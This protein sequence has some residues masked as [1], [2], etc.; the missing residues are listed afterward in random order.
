MRAR[1]S[2]LARHAKASGAV[3][4]LTASD[5]HVEDVSGF[6]PVPSATEIAAW[7]ESALDAASGTEVSIR[8]VGD[9]ESAALNERFRGRTGPTNV[10]AFAGPDSVGESESQLLGDVVIC[11]PVVARE[12]VEQRVA[13]EAHWA[14]I[15]IHG[16]LH[17]L[18]YEHDSDT[19]ARAME[20]R[21]AALLARFGFDDPYR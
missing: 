19:G 11:A 8:I 4:A 12:A 21:E 1:S 7:V 17:L 18:G 2:V 6:E 10:L 16:V 13:V 3:S 5:V 15:A 9:A 20:R 14:H